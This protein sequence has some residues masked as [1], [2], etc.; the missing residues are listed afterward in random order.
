MSGVALQAAAS[1]NSVASCAAYGHAA[2]W[3]SV[4]GFLATASRRAFP[5]AGLDRLLARWRRGPGPAAGCTPHTGEHHPPPREPAAQVGA[6]QGDAP[7]AIPQ[8]SPAV[9][10]ILQRWLDLSE[11]ERHAFAALAR[12][13]SSAAGLV[14]TST[15]SIADGFRSLA[16]LAQAQSER[17]D[18]VIEAANT[19]TIGHERVPFEQVT[20]FMREVLT[21]E[22]ET[23]RTFSELAAKMQHA[24]DMALAEAGRSEEGVARIEAL[25]RQTRYL[26][27]NALIE[28]ARAGEQG[29]GFAVVANEV[30][31]LSQAT[32]KVADSIRRQIVAMADGVRNGYAI[33][34]DIA[35][36]DLSRRIGCK[37]R[38]DALAA[39]MTAQNH[40]FNAILVDAAAS[41]REL[42]RTVAGLVMDL[43]F[44]DRN[45]QCLAHVAGTL[46][47]LSDLLSELQDT[48]EAVP[49]VRGRAVD[50][51][52]LARVLSNHTLAEVRDRFALIAPG[53][54]AAAAVAKGDDGGGIELF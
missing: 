33:V 8:A 30:R 52:A 16:T 28:A 9:V 7:P 48:T 54:A 43:Q 22:V 3:C 26:S 29:R 44:Q 38:L 13:V 24:L 53:G 5:G 41:A 23:L 10:D 39:A 31:D 1:V 49:A 50:Q 12:E 47:V 11:L 51:D 21:D 35:G 36:I 18:N 20:G 37:E 4:A 42:S 14:E 6:P 27:L 19:L 46:G 40:R 2:P 17:V 32:D 15:Q 45:S 34:G 25:N